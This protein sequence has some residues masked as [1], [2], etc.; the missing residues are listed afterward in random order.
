MQNMTVMPSLRLSPED[1]QDIA[2]YLITQKKQ[3]PSAYAERFVHGRSE[4]EGRRQEVG[5]A[6]RLRRMPRDLPASKTKA[7]SAP[8]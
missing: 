2:T 7:A 8:N 1:A 5:S 3:D 4:A 6:L